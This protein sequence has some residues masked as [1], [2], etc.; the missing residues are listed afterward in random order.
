MAT[1]ETLAQEIVKTSE[2]V[3]MSS[4]SHTVSLV[5]ASN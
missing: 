1:Y 4:A 2:A 3:T 5:Y